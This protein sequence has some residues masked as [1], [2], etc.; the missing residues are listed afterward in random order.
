C[1]TDRRVF[2]GARLFRASCDDRNVLVARVTVPSRAMFA[3]LPRF[4][5]VEQSNRTPRLRIESALDRTPAGRAKASLSEN[6]AQPERVRHLP[7][8]VR[9]EGD[10]LPGSARS[11]ARHLRSATLTPQI[12]NRSP[13]ASAKRQSI[14][15]NWWRARQ[16][17]GSRVLAAIPLFAAP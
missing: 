2:S 10:A 8:R 13:R 9:V 3:G 4:Q 11:R 1:F 17:R 5:R 14:R 7:G 6:D 16:T 12:G 15:R